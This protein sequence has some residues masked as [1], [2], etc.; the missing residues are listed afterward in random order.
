MNAKNS[1]NWRVGCGVAERLFGIGESKVAGIGNG[2][3]QRKQLAVGS[4]S[5]LPM[6]HGMEHFYVALQPK[7]LAGL[8]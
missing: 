6:A 4:T 7:L 2:V 3:C 1:F 5:P 8:R